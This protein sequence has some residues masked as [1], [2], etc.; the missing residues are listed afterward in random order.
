MILDQIRAV[1]VAVEAVGQEFLDVEQVY[2]KRRDK[3]VCEIRLD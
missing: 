1:A 3:E 2:E